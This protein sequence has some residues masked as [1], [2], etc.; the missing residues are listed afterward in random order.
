MSVRSYPT[1]PPAATLAT[2]YTPDCAEPTGIVG[3]HPAHLAALRAIE[4][5]A[6]Y[7]HADP[8]GLVYSRNRYYDPKAGRFT[9]E[10]PIGIAGGLNVYGFASGDPVSYSD[11]FGLCPD[12]KDP[13]C[14]EGTMVLTLTAGG[15]AGLGKGTILDRGLGIAGS[16]GLAVDN[17][18]NMMVFGTAGL[19]AS[20]GGAAHY[21]FG[22]QKG[23]LNGLVSNS[24]EGGGSS[25]T[26]VA[27]GLSGTL[28]LDD[29]HNLSGAAFGGGTGAGVAIQTTQLGRGATTSIG[30]I[31]QSFQNDMAQ[32]RAVMNQFMNDAY[33]AMARVPY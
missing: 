7:E 26:G 21:Q 9:Q 17:R 15:F 27:G 28:V 22:L 32:V 30:E 12:P 18:G 11:P 2:K 10:D 19:S 31:T 6:P 14:T 8:T 20:S 4:S 5:L 1:S 16:G 13:K 24:R 33:R 3:R 23:N 25:I 29:N